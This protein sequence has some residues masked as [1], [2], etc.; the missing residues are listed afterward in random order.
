MHF[1]AATDA[2]LLSLITEP[3][4]TKTNCFLMLCVTSTQETQEMDDLR[5]ATYVQPGQASPAMLRCLLDY[6]FFLPRATSVYTLRTAKPD[7]RTI[8][9]TPEDMKRI[10][11][12]CSGCL[13]PGRQINRSLGYCSYKATQ[14]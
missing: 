10:S 13:S 9:S 5:Y 14:G 7:T 11:H 8:S 3:T 4:D 2:L 6:F 1:H 12:N